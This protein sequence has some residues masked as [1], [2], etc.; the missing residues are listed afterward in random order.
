MDPKNPTVSVLIVS[1][2]V[3]Q[4]LL[5][6]IDT[7]LSSSY[8]GDIDV[9]VVDNNSYDGSAEAIKDLPENIQIIHNSTNL[10]FGKAVNQA[11]DVANGDY[12]LILNPD[13]I[14]EE[15]TVETFVN[16]MESQNH[17][18]M[19]GPK[20][21]NTD[22]SLQP[23]CKRSFPRPMVALPKLLGLSKLFPR[24]KW[25]GKYNLT[26][27]DP[28]D[29]HSVEAI[30]GSC[31]FI[32][33]DLYHDLHGFDER[34]F[35]FGEDL[36]LCF[37]VKI[38]GKE[39]HYL[40]EAKIIHFHGESVKSAPY[41]SIQA[42]YSAMILFADKYFSVGQKR[43]TRFMVK[44]GVRF[45]KTIAIIGGSKSQ[46]LSISLD[47]FAV[48][49]AFAIA[50]PIRFTDFEP[51]VVTRGFIPGIYVVFWLIINATFQ[52]YSRYILSYTRA[53][54]SSLSGFF[55]ATAFTYF[56]KQFAFSRLVIIVATLLITVLIPGWRMLFHYWMSRGY[57]TQ[58]K[59]KNNI[60]FARKTLII[61]TDKEAIRIAKHLSKR[62]ETGLE[63]VGFCD[64]ELT[65]PQDELPIPFVGRISDIRGIIDK[66]KIRE[67][68]F[69]SSS[70][71]S[72]NGLSIMDNTKDLRLTYRM[73]PRNQ[74]ILL[75][76]A[77]IEELGDYSF[78]HIEYTLFHRVN[79]VVKRLFDI[80]FASAIM[81]IC[82]PVYLFMHGR[83]I[84]QDYW[85]EDNTTINASI[86]DSKIQFIK[87]LP[88]MAQIIQGKMSF[89][90]S[91]LVPT[92]VDDP[93]LI[94]IPG[95]TGMQRLRNIN[96]SADDQ[97][98]LD[99]YYIQNQGLTLDLEIILKTV[100]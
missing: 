29:I 93:H 86:F 54:L 52:L 75:G 59:D 38:S 19:V 3:K 77:S 16:Y 34:Y 41:D 13:T 99:H 6:C 95:L 94:C 88:L 31:M 23:A 35:M 46:I 53:I 100:F 67:I 15:S 89:V 81:I 61:G 42:F 30:S 32:R 12:Y 97:R 71:V 11:A 2:N 18:G 64:S 84:R 49:T 43:M 4:Y 9:V 70:Y 8:K 1:Y 26:Y 58:V 82:S 85:G 73:V 17:V 83:R 63:L 60:L 74:D 92:N 98:V 79:W 57:F 87:Y 44:A 14:L 48:L 51:V 36:D 78:V 25:A 72:K 66:L 56:F 62:F 50:I 28:D 47:A 33:S 55:I 69:P 80:V 68:I 90:G 76:K 27:L 37:Q 65:V 20:I 22:G 24:S 96:F 5:H 7:V 40:P 21:L 10:G 45:R 91:K 39:I